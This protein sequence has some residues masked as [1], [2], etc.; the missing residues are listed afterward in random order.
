MSAASS[1]GVSSSASLI[2]ST[3]AVTGSRIASTISEEDILT[4]FGSPVS[5]SLPLISIYSSCGFGCAA[6][7]VSLISS[8]VRSPITRLCSLFVYIEMDSSSLSPATRR[9]LEFT[10]PPIE[11]TATSL[12]PPPISTT[13]QPVASSIGR[14]A[15]IAASSGSSNKRGF[16]LAPAR[17]AASSTAMYS[18]SVTPEGTQIIRFG[19]PIPAAEAAFRIK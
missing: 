7:I 14:P 9:D 15:P 19:L 4:F 8:A 11:M 1:G 12:V 6:P 13:M 18:T 3:M 16:F 2:A 17:S 10:I 5:K